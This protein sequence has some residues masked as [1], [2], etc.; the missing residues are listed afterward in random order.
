MA[1]TDG[2]VRDGRDGRTGGRAGRADGGRRDGRDGGPA[3]TVGRRAR[4]VLAPRD[5]GS[6]EL[7][8]HLLD[9]GQCV[10]LVGG[11]IGIG[12]APGEPGGDQDEAGLLERL[13][14]R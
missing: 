4:G 14:R 9:V 1:S 6:G 8:E 13:D 11:A 10:S 3:G 5:G 12:E 2:G 7:E